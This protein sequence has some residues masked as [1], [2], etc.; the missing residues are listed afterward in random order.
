M[1]RGKREEEEERQR[2]RRELARSM[3]LSFLPAWMDAAREEKKREKREDEARLS[4][5]QESRTAKIRV[6]DSE[7]V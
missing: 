4:V 1:K 7:L 2:R 5:D 3:T 6:S